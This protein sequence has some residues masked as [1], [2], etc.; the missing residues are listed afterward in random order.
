MSSKLTN[1]IRENKLKLI[2]GGLG[3]LTVSGVAAYFALNNSND[4]GQNIKKNKSFVQGTMHYKELSNSIKANKAKG[5]KSLTD[6]QQNIAQLA[7]N[8]FTSSINENL[9]LHKSYYYRGAIY[10]RLDMYNEA[11]NDASKAIESASSNNEFIKAYISQ[12]DSYNKLKQYDNSITAYNKALSYNPTKVID[13]KNINKK[14][15]S[16][17]KAQKRQ[18]AN[19]LKLKQ[20]FATTPVKEPM[21]TSSTLNDSISD[22]KLDKTD[23]NDVNEENN[24]IVSTKDDG[25]I[26]VVDKAP[27]DKSA[28]DEGIDFTNMSTTGNEGNEVSEA[29]QPIDKSANDEGIDFTNMSTW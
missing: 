2:F 5:I 29:A 7:I 19:D 11:L 22:I 18:E 4:D 28:N 8:E 24:E 9:E 15:A 10:L 23:N 26:V 21:E 1:F 25:S 12:G 3:I 16:V 6:D 14:L 27:I 20:A 17:S 13:I